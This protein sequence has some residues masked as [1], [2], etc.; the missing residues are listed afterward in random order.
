MSKKNPHE[1]IKK[2]LIKQFSAFTAVIMV[3]ATIVVTL[4]LKTTLT[5]QLHL[6]LADHAYHTTIGIEQRITFLTES[7]KAF[8]KNHFVINGL[9][10][11]QGNAQDCSELQ[12]RK[13]YFCC[14]DRQF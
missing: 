1:S 12:C 9:I 2:R 6:T 11:P 8:S 13:R 7:T 4:I 10:D 3:L 5:R 14:H